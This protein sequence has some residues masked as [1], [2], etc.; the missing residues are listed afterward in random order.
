MTTRRRVA[1]MPDSFGGTLSAAEAASAMAA[2]W[3]R[4]RPQ[5][6]LVLAPQSDG[7]PGFLEVLATALRRPLHAATV[8]GPLGRPVTAQTLLHDG[9]AYLEA[10]QACGLHLLDGPPTPDTA[11][12]AGSE[13]VGELI[14]LALRAGAGRIVIGL[15]GSACTDGGRGMCGALGG[16]GAAR[17]RLAGVELI[18]ASDVDNP[19][20]GP[21]GAA[22]VFGPQK[23]ADPP[24]VAELEQRLTGWARELQENT[25][26]TVQ[27][28]PG[29]GAAG[30]LG[31]ALLACGARRVSG[32]ALVAELSDRR[33]QIA[34]GDLVL[35]GE[36]RLDAQTLRGKLV[37]QV[38]AEAAEAWVPVLVLAGQVALEPAA[39]RRLGEVFSLAEFTGSPQSA[40]AGAEAALADL[41]AHI[42][43]SRP[44]GDDADSTAPVRE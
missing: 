2:G 44:P 14:E 12:T 43:A 11:L 7:G 5:D 40:L 36:G 22:A 23:G 42:A 32:A 25:G 9:T 28:L 4:S 27:D 13:G 21:A 19:L 35:T 38:A 10:A 1:I 31:A 8:T 37:A 24:A 30:G 33:A 15:G 16:I 3:H 26:V 29:A 39:C 20:L 41:A 17:D 6:T 18:A 34:A